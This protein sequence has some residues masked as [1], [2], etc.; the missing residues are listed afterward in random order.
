MTFVTTTSKRWASVALRNPAEGLARLSIKAEV[1]L[2][3]ALHDAGEAQSDYARLTT[4]RPFS[5]TGPAREGNWNREF[6]EVWAS[7]DLGPVEGGHAHDADA[8]L[9]LAAYSSVRESQA[10]VVV[11]TGVARG[12]TSR[13]VLEALR[14]NVSPGRLISVDLPPLSGRWEEASRTA[15]PDSLRANW[16]YLR[17]STRQVLPRVAKRY[18]VWDVF[19][20]DSGHTYRNMRMEFQLATHALREQGWLIADDIEDNRAFLDYIDSSRKYSASYLKGAK[21][22]NIVGVAQRLPLQVSS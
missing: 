12:I 10:Q 4:T 20:H 6:D 2:D 15:V 18:P 5:S 14:R 17:G 3:P 7:L 9:A 8:S 21:K 16:T 13:V 22:Q 19:I 11:E 1:L